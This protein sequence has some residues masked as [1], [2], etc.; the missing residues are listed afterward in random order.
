M[1]LVAPCAAAALELEAHIEAVRRTA[2]E[3]LFYGMLAIFIQELA[4]F[5]IHSRYSRVS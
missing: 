3:V 4:T 1:P 5:W 2:T